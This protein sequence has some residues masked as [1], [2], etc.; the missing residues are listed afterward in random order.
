M[1]IN[2]ISEWKGKM[3]MTVEVGSG[4]KSSP[5]LIEKIPSYGKRGGDYLLVEN[6][7]IYTGAW[8]G[9]L[10]LNLHVYIAPAEGE[11]ADTFADVSSAVA[12]VNTS[13]A[14]L[15]SQPD[16]FYAAVS[17]GGVAMSSLLSIAEVAAQ[18]SE[19]TI[20]LARVSGLI[21]DGKVPAGTPTGNEAQLR[22]L[23]VGEGDIDQKFTFDLR[24]NYV[25][26]KQDK[27]SQMTVT[28]R[29][30]IDELSEDAHK[31]DLFADRKEEGE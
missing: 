9:Y 24:S 30:V 1:Q 22:Y 12:E 10:P 28:L 15:P 6:Y 3:G 31:D 26:D 27:A 14:A 8:N 17:T 5:L 11:T 29:L 21:I 13:L 19:K 20:T 7:P 2:E 18:F 23:E 25:E 16:S 4:D